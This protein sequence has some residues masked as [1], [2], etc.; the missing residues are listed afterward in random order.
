MTR[1]KHQTIQGMNLQSATEILSW[2]NESF[3][4]FFNF[5]IL[6]PKQMLNGDYYT[7]W[8]QRKL[9][10]CYCFGEEAQIKSGHKTGAYSDFLCTDIGLVLK[11]D[12]CEKEQ[13][14]AFLS[15]GLELAKDKYDSECFRC[16]VPLTQKNAIKMLRKAGFQI[17][18]IFES[19]IDQEKV[20]LLIMILKTKK[21]LR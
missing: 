10:G 21:N 8:H 13:I 9:I 20:E 18:K 4:T 14:M 16:T 15:H 2:K 3:N 7:V 5:N 6:E 1:L 11:P 12:Y 19:T 17:G